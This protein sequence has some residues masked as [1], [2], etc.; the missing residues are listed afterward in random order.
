[1]IDERFQLSKND[2]LSALWAK[3]TVHL[4]D[5]L[6]ELR[7]QNDGDLTEAQTAKHRG[8]IAEVKS[9]LDLGEDDPVIPT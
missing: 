6:A 4:E 2:K 3:I 1:M 9:L 5:R 7:A 8:R